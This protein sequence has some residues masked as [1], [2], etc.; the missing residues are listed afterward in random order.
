MKIVTP[1]TLQESKSKSNNELPSLKTITVD[2]SVKNQPEVTRKLR[3]VGH[4][5]EFY[6][7]QDKVRVG[8]N[9]FV[10]KPF[11]DAH[12][13]SNF[14]RIAHEDPEKCP[15]RKLG[16]VLSKRYA[17]R[18]FEQQE[19]GSWVHKILVKGPLVF[20]PL[21]DWEKGR[22]DEA[23]DDNDDSL[24]TFLGSKVAPAVKIVAVHDSSKLGQVDYT[25]HVNTKDMELTEDM[26]NMLRAVRVP[27]AD[28]LSAFRS[29]YQKL[30]DEGHD[31]PEFQDYFTYGHDIARIFKFTPMKEDTAQSAPKTE[32]SSAFDDEE[33]TTETSSEVDNLDLDMSG[34]DW[35]SVEV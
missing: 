31:I 5:M 28:E 13:N 29:N 11:P 27:P 14:T 2:L 17:Q 26:I 30:I 8:K 33:T 15:W 7:V 9:E 21:F 16:Y 4:A 10:K 18:C 35:P 23:A 25:V 6:E 32:T 19:D 1:K 12:L 34:I 3:M 22:R 24:S 20:N